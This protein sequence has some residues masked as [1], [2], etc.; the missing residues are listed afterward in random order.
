M[1]VAFLDANIFPHT[2]LTDVLLTFADYHLFDPAFSDDVLEEARCA[3][4]E[5]LGKDPVWVDRYLAAIRNIRPYYL[6]SSTPEL[7]DEVVLPDAD[8]RHVAAAAHNGDADVI[9]TFNLKD[10]PTSQLAKIGLA[11]RHPD[12]FLASLVEAYPER[13]SKAMIELVSSKKHPPRTMQEELDRL[14]SSGM[15]EFASAMRSVI[16]LNWRTMCTG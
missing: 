4:V 16:R 15:P 5:D 3:F 7:A 1:V 2:W 6:V 12:E 14:E 8:D 10:F 11:A 9:V 13:A